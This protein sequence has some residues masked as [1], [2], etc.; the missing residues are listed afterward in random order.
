M[1]K[2][3]TIIIIVVAVALLG[4]KSTSYVL[5][6]KNQDALAIKST[7]STTPKV[8]VA[9]ANLCILSISKK[10]DAANKLQT[11]SNNVINLDPG[12]SRITISKAKE[13]LRA[14]LKNSDF[15]ADSFIL[16]RIISSNACNSLLRSCN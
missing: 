4:W 6:Q 15:F 16:A 8:T 1:H 12:A 14:A 10:M 7:A 5:N 9:I 2:I 13:A 11:A 3:L